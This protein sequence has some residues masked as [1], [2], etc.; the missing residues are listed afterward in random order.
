[1]LKLQSAVEQGTYKSRITPLDCS[2]PKFYWIFKNCDFKQW[3]TGKTQVLWLSAPKECSMDQV[4]SDIVRRE[5]LPDEMSKPQNFILYFF[6]ETIARKRQ[7]VS[8]YIHTLLHQA[9][10]C[11]P[12]DKRRNAT[13]AF[14]RTLF[15]R[16]FRREPSQFKE[17]DSQSTIVNKVLSASKS[18]ELFDA[19]KAAMDIDRELKMTVIVSGLDQVKDQKSEFIRG[20]GSFIENLMER[21]L[22]VKALLSSLPRADVQDILRELACIEY[23]KERQGL[24]ALWF[25]IV[26]KPPRTDRGRM[27]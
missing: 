20:V 5:L 8:I 27:S 12:L 17:G 26:D 24:A 4:C 22:G 25:P 15:K 16:I 7:S 19:L 14:L 3:K 18:S 1:M 6:C 23:D 2:Q 11:L 21:P 10:H 13:T 9:L